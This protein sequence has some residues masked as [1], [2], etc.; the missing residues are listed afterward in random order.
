MWG[1][2]CVQWYHAMITIIIE[3]SL[4]L[5]R[6]PR[7]SKWLMLAIAAAILA[8]PL[9]VSAYSSGA[10]PE[11]CYSM[12][13]I[14]TDPLTNTMVH[15]IP[16][17]NNNNCDGL[18][19]TVTCNG[20]SDGHYSC[21]EYHQGKSTYVSTQT[22]FILCTSYCAVTLHS[23][24]MFT[25]FLIQARVPVPGIPFHMYRIVGTFVSSSPEVSILQCNATVD[26]PTD[27]PQQ[28]M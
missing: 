21:N 20:V 26:S 24:R 28:V 6:M 5:N 18:T 2:H 27:R 13:A 16:C 7:N 25:G 11:S 8:L 10:P 4:F 9:G 3:Q 14:H 17:G 19:L 1:G 22:A 12:L 15:S 23:T